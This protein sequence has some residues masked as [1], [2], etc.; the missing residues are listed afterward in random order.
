M[1]FF[2]FVVAA[3]LGPLTGWLV[4]SGLDDLCLYF[5][6][7]LTQLRPKAAPP[8]QE[9]LFEHPRKLLAIFVPLWQEHEVVRQ[10]VL[11]NLTALKYDRVQIFIGA[12]PN[13]P[14]TCDEV[15]WLEGQMDRV[16]LAQVPH[17]GP[18]SKADC[19]NWVYQRML[20]E[21]QRLG[22]KFEAIIT[23]DAE[24]LIHP[25]SL[26][27]IN[28]YLDQVDMVQVPVL[29][30][31]TPAWELVHGIYMD[32]FSEF[33][34]RDLQVRERFG[35]FLP[36]SGVGTGFSRRA[37]ESLADSDADRIF[38]PACLTE[39]YENGF[40]LKAMG[41][42]Q[43]FLPVFR[44]EGSLVATRE[45][46]P[47]K[48][49]AAVRQRTR[50]VTGIVWQGWEKHGF[51]GGLS[52]QWWHWR[53][54]KGILGNPIGCLANV[55]FVYMLVRWE[56]VMALLADS[57]VVQAM[58]FTLAMAVLHVT[59]RMAIVKQYYSW[60]IT[61]LVPVRIVL[62]NWL[63]TSASLRAMGRYWKA[64]WQGQ[65]LVWLK[66]TH[67]YPTKSDLGAHRPPLEEILVK[68]Q[69]VTAAALAEAQAGKPADVTLPDWLLITNVL[70]EEELW[71]AMAL[72]HCLPLD[73][74]ESSSVRPAVAQALPATVADQFRLVPIEIV[75]GQLHVA[76]D[77]P[78]E[79]DL[80]E[81]LREYTSFA[82]K[83]HL[84]PRSN[85]EQLRREAALLFE[86]AE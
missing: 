33:Q 51:G 31:A 76:G 22:Q 59:S 9:Q 29:P 53:D 8:T 79:G 49:K 35:G 18:T 42:G 43:T 10:M 21:E 36:S 23:H 82:I 58:P 16:H 32:E 83:F 70:P 67:Q 34:T 24:D 60:P 41:Y 64:K 85:Y 81:A 72:Q 4:L 54:R 63:N 26:H 55:L 25:E 17:D 47:R 5:A 80:A 69:Y 73:Q 45:Y 71:E 40:R 37:L 3:L 7:A 30:L 20:R 77:V 56:T 13:D 27:W 84:V 19:L 74:V 52:Q 12:Y 14:K 61:L 62:A 38:D 11:H 44:R 68:N 75:D 50:W 78:P 86:H 39:D 28:F 65:G 15:R 66:T 48:W 2:D 6:W 57:W 1:P 46:F